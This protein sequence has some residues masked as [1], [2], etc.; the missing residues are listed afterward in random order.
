M[1]YSRAREQIKSGDILLWTHRSWASWYDIQIQF[2]RMGTQ[3]KYCHVGIAWKIADRLFVLEAVGSGIRIYPLSATVPF[4][5]IARD[6]W[7]EEHEIKALSVIGEKYSK[8]E[9]IKGLFGLT[10][11]DN[12]K[13][14]CAEYVCFVLDLPVEKATPANVADFLLE[15]EGLELYSVVGEKK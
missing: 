5:V 7:N 9:A 6:D 2:V 12:H 14:E 3:S 15:T 11:V 8:W 13:W 1:L 10:S 4:D